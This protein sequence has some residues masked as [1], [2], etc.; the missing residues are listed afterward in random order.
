MLTNGAINNDVARHLLLGEPEVPDLPVNPLSWWLTLIGVFYLPLLPAHRLWKHRRMQRA[1]EE[2]REARREKA[3]GR[4]QV[5][6]EGLEV[7]LLAMILWRFGSWQA[8]S[9]AHWW[10]SVSLAAVIWGWLLWE[11]R[12]M[13]WVVERGGRKLG[14]VLGLGFGL[15]GLFLVGWVWR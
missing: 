3:G 12:R 10:V 6:S 2:E 7:A 13:P 11:A 5:L 1:P 14:L 4:L 9:M 8:L 15:L